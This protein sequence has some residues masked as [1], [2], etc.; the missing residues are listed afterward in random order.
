MKINEFGK[1]GMQVSEIGFGGSR[2]GGFFANKNGGQEALKVLPESLDSGIT[3]YDTADMYAQGESEALIGKAF[4]GRRQQVVLATKGGYCLPAQR[5]LMQRIKPLVRPIVHALGL[6]RS[7]LPSLVSGAL[8]QDFSPSYLTAALEAS[9]KRLQTDYIDIYQLHSPPPAFLH[10]D[11]FGEALETL[12]KLKSQGKL[13]FYGVAVEAAEQA[14]LCLSAPG[15]GSLQLG[16]GLLDLEALDQGILAAAES[17]GLGVIARGC[18]GGGLLKDGLNEAQL[19]AA[20]PKWQRILTLRRLSESFG[21]PVLETAL[22]F[23]RATP[24][25]GVTLL[26]MHTERHLSENLRYVQAPRLNEGEYE[27]LCHHL[28]KEWI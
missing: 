15:I 17:R 11:A 22:Q 1:T 21:R 26:G 27:A 6:K 23:C 18:F 9:L 3:F 12:E 20:T 24:G 25:V 7:K 2:I 4:R 28:Q 5:K 16:F 8:S 14:E 19:E 10:S 13:R